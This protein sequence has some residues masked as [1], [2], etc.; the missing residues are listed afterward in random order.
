MTS[1]WILDVQVCCIEIDVWVSAELQR[2][3]QE[4][5][6]LGIEPLADAAQLRFGDTALTAQRSHQPVNVAGVDT[7]DISLHHNHPQSPI[8]AATWLQ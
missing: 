4:S 8:D 6:H 3:I 2:P 1:G 7:K 5:L